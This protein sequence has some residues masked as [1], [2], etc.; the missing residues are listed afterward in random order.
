MTP[1]SGQAPNCQIRNA[2]R[3]NQTYRGIAPPPPIN[4]MHRFAYCQTM[5]ME[6]HALLSARQWAPIDN[7]SRAGDMAWLELF[8][9][10]DIRGGRTSAGKHMKSDDAKR[11][12]EERKAQRTRGL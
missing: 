1:I 5:Y 6:V 7:N 12:S 3:C 4:G 2:A 11:R 9:L 10:F 8:V